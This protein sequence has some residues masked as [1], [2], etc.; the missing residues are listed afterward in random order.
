VN[1]KLRAALPTLLDLVIPVAGYYALSACG[2]DD[3]WALTVSGIAT[4]A[5]ALVRTLRRRRL[6]GIGLLVVIEIALSLVLLGVTRDPRI[7]LLKPSFYTVVG[8]L[9]LLWT[10]VA[11][12]PLTV[13]TARPFGTR[14]DP[15]REAEWDAA[16]AHAG[17]FRR[18]HVRLTAVWAVLF[19]VEAVVR[20]A[21]VLHLSVADAVLAAQVPG[22]AVFVV[23]GVYSRL[24]IP[25]LRRALARETADAGCA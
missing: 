12:R 2:L 10:C 6:D 8:A 21:I 3:F 11:G 18:E 15:A 17:P 13:E 25:A 19:L 4:G 7:V 1:A 23:G 20:G 9:F 22:I 24:R 16:A 14:G 5:Y